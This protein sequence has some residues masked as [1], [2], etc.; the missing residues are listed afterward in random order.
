MSKALGKSSS[1]P[2]RY[3]YIPNRPGS[4]GRFSA[5]IYRVGRPSGRRATARRPEGT[6]YSMKTIEKSAP[7]PRPVSYICIFR[8]LGH[9]THQ[10]VEESQSL[11]ARHTCIMR[12]TD[13]CHDVSKDHLPVFAAKARAA[14]N[15]ECPGYLKAVWPDVFGC[16]F[17]VW[18]AP[19]APGILQKGGGRSPPRF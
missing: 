13:Q 18:L 4:R 15:A 14:L 5:G 6:S 2:E 10:N 12:S 1:E 7:G 3:S 17:E 8:G 9:L 16:I 11:L 19:G